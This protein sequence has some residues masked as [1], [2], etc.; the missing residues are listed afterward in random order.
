MSDITQRTPVE[1]GST[2]IDQASTKTAAA[3][4][5]LFCATCGISR[6][7]LEPRRGS[8][9]ARP[10]AYVPRQPDAEGRPWQSNND[11]IVHA[12]VYR[13]GGTGEDAHLC[14]RCLTIGLRAL[15]V[16]IDRA[17]DVADETTD[18]AAELMALTNRI[19]SLEW[20][21]GNLVHDHDRM[22]GRLRDLLAIAQ[23]PASPGADEV[24]RLAQFEAE[25][26]SARVCRNYAAAPQAIAN[27]KDK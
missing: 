16:E 7:G 23:I 11:L 27:P 10:R 22:Q 26:Q 4:R 15:K 5:S 17:L 12:A 13:N 21:R 9:S 3:D 19:A 2:A 1:V 6:K 20:A 18:R 24:L 8:W 14:D 25:R